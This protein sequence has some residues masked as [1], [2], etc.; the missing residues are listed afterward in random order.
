LESIDS[1][2]NAA[3]HAAAVP[4]TGLAAAAGDEVSA[5]ISALFAGY[6]KEFQA[7][8][9]HARAF[10]QQFV[11]ALSSGSR[12]YLAT[13]AAGA[14]WLKAVQHELLGAVNAP[15]GGLWGRALVGTGAIGTAANA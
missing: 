13:E 8:T 5:A 14:S 2:L 3:H 6:G 12:A 10:H 15:T 7:L 11:Q 4:T 9:A 1:A